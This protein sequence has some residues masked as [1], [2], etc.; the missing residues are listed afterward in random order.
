MY[1]CMYRQ[2]SLSYSDTDQTT[3]NTIIVGQVLMCPF[4]S[5]F[6][7][8]F[9]DVC[10]GF[11]AFFLFI[12]LNV[13]VC[14]TLYPLKKNPSLEW[15]IKLP[16]STRNILSS[17][18]S[19]NVNPI[20]ME[21]WTFHIESHVSLSLTQLKCCTVNITLYHHDCLRQMIRSWICT[22]HLALV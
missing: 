22:I 4:S 13:K 21:L 19:H 1:P 2:L 5:R 16:R 18:Y 8:R 12:L 11:L 3:K 15:C 20:W 9:M 14:Y 7:N 17:T 10:F 6:L